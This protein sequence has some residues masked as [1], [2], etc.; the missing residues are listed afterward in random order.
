VERHEAFWI[1]TTEQTSFPSI[2]SDVKVDVAIIGGGI[3]GVMA[4]TYLK[5]A[6]KTVALL[7]AHKMLEG[8]TGHTTAKVTSLH[9][10]IYRDLVSHFG[11]DN[12]RRY[13]AANEWAIRAI[14]TISEERGIDCDLEE[15]SAYTYTTSDEVVS[16][17]EA[18]VETARSLGLP[19]EYYD[20]VPLRF[21]VRAAIGFSGQLQFHPRRFLIPLATA[22]PGDG[23][24]V[25]EGTRVINLDEGTPNRV[26]TEHGSVVTADDVIVATNMPIL[27]KGMF[28]ARAEPSRGYALAMD[29]EPANAPDGMFINAGSPTRSVRVAPHDG[30]AVLILS[31]EGHHV[32]EDGE[33][34]ARWERLARWGRD[35]LGGR[36]VAYRWSTQDFYSLDKIPFIGRMTPGT[37][38]LFTA[39]AF[40][41]WGMAHGVVAGKLLSDLITDVENEWADVYD[42]NRIDVKSLPPFVKK[43]GHDAK[44]FVGGRLK[45][46]PGPDETEIAPGAGAV[47]NVGGEKVAVHRDDNGRLHPVSAVCTHL[48]CIVS[49]N[50]AE[51][52]WDCPCHGS[53]FAPS[54]EVLHGPAAAPL[55]PKDDVLAEARTE[56]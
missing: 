1:G 56:E 43:G 8:V 10:L 12:A 7:E 30:G 48:G 5:E 52:S 14:R 23:S 15:K 53:R 38:R 2:P 42:P 37:S 4:A 35:D 9:T 33:N 11:E 16:D 28:F 36:G 31:G 25:F 26:L 18:E 22:V 17:I 40:S 27:N 49:W 44:R 6:G 55:E 32:G 34:A 24:H 29:I 45:R 21:P 39:T 47:V 3:V 13:G 51:R 54:G 19:A 41:A 46:A 20:E 50:D